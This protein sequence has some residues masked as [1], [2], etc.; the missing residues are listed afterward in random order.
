MEPI[1]VRSE[2]NSNSFFD[3]GRQI[4]GLTM[5]LAGEVDNT[6]TTP[7]QDIEVAM[8]IDGCVTPYGPWLTATLPKTAV[9]NPPTTDVNLGDPKVNPVPVRAAWLTPGQP[10]PTQT[11]DMSMRM[12][13]DDTI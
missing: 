4:G 1:C 11:T 2:K 13:T 3:L 9:Y 5:I 12:G 10:P 8:T 6:S 7:Q